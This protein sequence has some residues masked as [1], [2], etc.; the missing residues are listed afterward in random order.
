MDFF[1]SLSN[2]KI[3][4]SFLCLFQTLFKSDKALRVKENILTFL[5][6]SAFPSISKPSLSSRE[7]DFPDYMTIGVNEWGLC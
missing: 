7:A 6:Q 1:K 3:F 5:W 4:I 2:L